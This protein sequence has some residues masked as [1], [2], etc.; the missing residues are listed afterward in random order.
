[1]TQNDISIICVYNKTDI[2]E[3][4]LKKSLQLQSLQAEII[5]VDNTN[6][7]YSSAAKALNYGASCASGKVFVFAH[8]DVSF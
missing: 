2:Y 1:M 7:E 5:A 8:Q 6:Q 4:V 3:N